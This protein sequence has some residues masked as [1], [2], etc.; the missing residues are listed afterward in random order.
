MRF[1]KC[2]YAGVLPALLLVA[3]EKPVEQSASDPAIQSAKSRL[4]TG[5]VSLS[6][7]EPAQRFS[8][9][10][11][12]RTGMALASGDLN[13]DGRSDIV[14]GAPG[15]ASGTFVSEIYV[16]RGNA[17]ADIDTASNLL[18]GV[19]AYRAG[20]SLG[21]GNFTGTAQ[22]D[23]LVGAP[24]Y[25]LN[26]GTTYLL[27]GTALSGG[28]V[29]LSAAKNI[30][31]LAANDTA[32]FAVALGDVTGSSD[33]D[34][35][36][37]APNRATGSG[38]VYVV[39]GPINLATVSTTLSGAATTI[40]GTAGN[41]IQAGTSLATA[42]INGDG[43]ADL[44]I[45]SPKHNGTGAVFVFFGPLPQSP[46][47]LSI[48]SANLTLLGSTANEL[49]GTSVARVPDIDGDGD[50]ELLVGAPGSGSLP[51]KA[52]LVYGGSTGTQALSTSPQ[53]VGSAGDL[54]GTSVATAGDTDQ[55]GFTD[56][57]VGAPGTASGA[58]AAYLIHGGPTPFS[59]TQPLSNFYRF[60]GESAGDGAGTTVAGVGD[61]DGDGRPDIAIGA[62][63]T[64]G[65]TGTVYLL[66]LRTWYEDRDGD[67]FGDSNRT[68]ED[69]FVPTPGA[70]V[71][72]GDDCDDSNGYV[73][74]DAA[75]ICNG[76]DD[77]CR[78]GIDIADP[79]IVG[80]SVYFTD[81]DGDK[82]IQPEDVG[83]VACN[84]PPGMIPVEA[85]YG[86][87]CSDRNSDDDATTYD[88]AEE[89][90]DTKDNN[91]DNTIDEG[92]TTDYFRDSDGD[93]YGDPNDLVAA[94]SQ[95]TGYV[96][97]NTD[98]D[99]TRDTVNPTAV[100][101][102]NGVDDNCDASPDT[103]ATWYVD[104]DGDG[105]GSDTPYPPITVAACGAPPFGYANN[106]DDCNDRNATVGG[107]PVWHP[108]TD[109]DGFGDASEEVKACTKPAGYVANDTDCD[110]TTNAVTEI[111]W[112]PDTDG[113]G[114]GSPTGH[115][116]ACAGPPDGYVALSTDCND[117][118]ASIAPNQAEVC[119]GTDDNCSGSTDEGVT[120]TF[121]R[122]SD[123]DG[124]GNL[125][126][127]TQACSVPSGYT[128][129]ATDCNDGDA[130]LNPQTLW[131]ADTDSDGFGSTTSTT[132]CVKP[133]GYVRGNTDCNDN[134]NT[135]Y[136]GAL[137]LCNG[138]DDDCNATV[139][140]STAVDTVTWYRD[141]DG[142]GHGQVFDSKKACSAPTGYVSTS[143]D[144]ND[145]NASMFPGNP[146]VCDGLDN[147]CDYEKDENV[148]NTV[149]RDVD[150]DGFGTPLSFQLVC[151]TPA[152]YVSNNQDC[153][154]GNNSIAPGLAEVCNGVDD[155]CDGVAD[156]GVKN[157]YYADQ[158]GDGFGTTNATY[159]T[160]ACSAPPGYTQTS[161]DCD[162]RRSEVS[163]TGTE[164]CDL[165]DNNC[166]GT[167]DEGVQLTWYQDADGDGFGVPGATTQA[168]TKPAG[169]SANT[170]DCDDSRGDVSPANVEVCEALGGAQVDNN[171]NGQVDDAINARTW[172]QDADNDGF[173]E[174]THIA[175]AC[176]PPTHYVD[177]AGDCDDTLANVY[178]Q[179]PESC[180]TT[181]PQI[182]N[183]CNGDLNDDPNAPIWYGD[184][185]GDNYAGT[186]FQLRWCT[187]PSNLT[188]PSGNVIVRGH[189]VPSLIPTDCND[190][191]VSISP[192]RAEICNNIDDNCDGQT[193]EGVQTAFYP[194]VD[195][196]GC[197]SN[198]AAPYMGC[199]S[200][201]AC[202]YSFVTNNTDKDDRNASV[203]L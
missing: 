131:Y 101:V 144:C 75:E 17:S 46:T 128:S 10:A 123:G 13:G 80:A 84:P 99:D 68:Q 157:T 43:K 65:T 191:N 163:P 82:F 147:N 126:N 28:T 136:P 124:F 181:G 40:T 113:D 62:P 58:G 29:Q 140:D 155:N 195:G 184:G 42:D 81:G 67:G 25:S 188:D 167:V 27:D 1:L 12:G 149:Y 138:Q 38:A 71:A 83:V 150:G 31:G 160:Q 35:I 85:V 165:L 194:D 24:G 92:V 120:T 202:G 189:Y 176:A 63:T 61:V 52:Y 87:E 134:S 115:V 88:G 7:V 26:R 23:L 94:C 19:N 4:V 179:A 190:S 166:D 64:G 39:K 16:L 162:D 122:D 125:N 180:E 44:V 133:D 59:A 49:A 76:I 114:F 175:Q 8:G 135:T 187:D 156:E 74:P 33:A 100:E 116:N 15:P 102:C 73:N 203:C 145:T 173:G 78:D 36:I 178:P 185:D 121:Y 41:A 96:A 79:A 108:D 117:G 143:D 22:S 103:N 183:N 141:G 161:G 55:D 171:C 177:K 192:G 89:V 197:G 6:K 60:S 69:Y 77:N 9:K 37:G 137:E 50:D 106:K 18:N 34:L 5:N 168:C 186:T 172:Y 170:S 146:E 30:A 51:G 129:D 11:G 104:L 154:D 20:T 127:P 118:N 86:F 130:T 119:N 152:G 164:V 98:C 196:D 158:D 112:Y 90:C 182:D 48:T 139:D 14:V 70:W 97:S 105:F 153:N 95:P 66:Y 45:G 56:L 2:C 169:Y 109:G 3:C 201:G 57:L 72:N 32:G 142:D 111:H 200:P 47:A 148:K 159:T 199:G 193:D 110:D 107:P 91:C 151:D 21:V 53:F 54:A 174:E 93:T 198:T 132:S